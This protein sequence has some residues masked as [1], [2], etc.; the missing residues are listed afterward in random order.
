MSNA[1]ALRGGQINS[2]GDADAL[3]L[4][5]YGGEVM[6]AFDE[7]N[8]FKEK[9]QV[10]N[11]SSGKSASFPATWKVN[12]KYHTPGVEITG[13][14]ANLAERVITIDKLLIADA[15]FANIDEAKT[16]FDYRSEYT[17]QT[18]V[19]LAN[20]YDKNVAQVGL[21]AARATATVTGG[22]GGSSLA[23]ATML[24]DKDVITTSLFTAAQKLDEKDVPESDRCAFFRPAQYYLLTQNTDLMNKDWGGR[25]SYADASLPTIAGIDLMKTNHLPSTDVD[26]GPANYQGDFSTTA[27]LVMHRAAVGT[28]QLLDLSMESEYDIR[29]QGTLV[30]SK[31]ALGHG[32]LR[33]ECAIEL[34]NTAATAAG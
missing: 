33:P 5:V 30:V 34:K 29:R 1:T 3:F 22:K 13:Q 2:A 15:F 28:V 24:T 20:Q 10:R 27:G 9:H 31:Y 7:A 16:H 19:A 12:A 32:I 8:V 23:S 6:A 18:G 26:S 11:I 17:R 21:L 14:T 4:K 25:G